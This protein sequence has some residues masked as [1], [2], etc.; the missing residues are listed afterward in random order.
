LTL[1]KIRMPVPGLFRPGDTNG[2]RKIP[3]VVEMALDALRRNGIRPALIQ[4]RGDAGI[5]CDDALLKLEVQ[6][7]IRDAFPL[8]ISKVF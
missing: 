8:P 7:S 6:G 4:A 3:M 2:R 1:S 5:V